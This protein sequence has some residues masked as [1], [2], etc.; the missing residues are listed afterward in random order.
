MIKETIG[1]TLRELRVAQGLTQQEVAEK[2]G[3]TQ[4]HIMRIELAKYAGTID[5]IDKVAR[6]LGAKL[7]FK[8][9]FNNDT[10][11]STINKADSVANYTATHTKR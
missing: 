7:T 6:A 5:T 3:L 2:C 9:L 8:K 4:T 1:K 10:P 11:T